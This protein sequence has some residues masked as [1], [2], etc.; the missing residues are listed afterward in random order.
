MNNNNLQEKVLS[1]LLSSG[2][3]YEDT[4]REIDLAKI[5]GVSVTPVR[6]AL[7]NLEDKGFVERRKRKGTYLKSF[8]LKEINELYDLRSVLEGLAARLLCEAVTPGVAGELKEIADEYEKNKPGRKRSVLADLDYRF[9]EGIVENCGNDRLKKQVKESH[10]I[11]KSFSRHESEHVPE[12]ALKNPYTH[13]RIVSAIEEAD[14]LK[15]ENFAR[16]HVEWAKDNT[17]R[18]MIAGGVERLGAGK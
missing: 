15:A 9:H 14:G 12:R 8:S 6:E 10:V 11:T 2:F 18:M 1:H 17:I 5:F 4:I 16:K 7:N 13:V 3:G